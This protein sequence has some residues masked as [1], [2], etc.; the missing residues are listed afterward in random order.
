LGGG[1]AD[2]AE[3]RARLLR[4]APT[5]AAELR[6]A[7]ADAVADTDLVVR[8]AVL[9]VRLAALVAA[10]RDVVGEATATAQCDPLRGVMTLAIATDAAE[11][12]LPRLAGAADAHRAHVVV[13]RWPAALAETITV[14]HPLPPALGLMRRMKEA[15]DPRGTLAPGRFVGRL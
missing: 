12:L 6:P 11:P 4:L 14:W 8:F 13:E 1:A 3:A 2:V 5:Y 10:L 15:L 9:P 7:A